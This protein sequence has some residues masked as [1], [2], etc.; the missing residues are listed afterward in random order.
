MQNGHVE[1]CHGRLCHECLNTSWF[2]TLNAWREE[3]NCERPHNSLDYRTPREFNL[4]QHN[5]LQNREN[6]SY[7]GSRKKGRSM[8]SG[9]RC[10]ERGDRMSRRARRHHTAASKSKVGLAT[11][12]GEK[13]LSELAQQFDMH[14]N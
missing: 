3:Y 12:K 9:L 8:A 11:L 5:Q 1:S 6:S 4:D 7:E 14:A 10:P 13:K 2:R